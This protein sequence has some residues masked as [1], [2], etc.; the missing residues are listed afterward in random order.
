METIYTIGV[1][2]TNEISFFETLREH[3]IDLFCDIRQ[4]R[5]LR[6]ARY[7]YANSTYLQQKLQGIEID[8][9]HYKGLAP[10][11]QMRKSQYVVDKENKVGQR[12]RSTLSE[13]FRDAYQSKILSVFDIEDFLAQTADYNRICFFCV[14]CLP[15][16]CH[17]SLATK[18][19]SQLLDVPIEHLTPCQ[20][21][22]S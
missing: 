21:P 19:I 1:Y 12:E 7:S 5:G 11:T 17:R 20:S 13:V 3:Q 22:E 14:E 16:A 10:T 18:H 8:Y 9:L 2:G 15:T 6:G 4:R